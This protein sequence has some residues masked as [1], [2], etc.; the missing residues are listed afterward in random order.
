MLWF[1]SSPRAR[2]ASCSFSGNTTRASPRASS[3][4]LIL[5]GSST[6]P[7]SRHLLSTE[8]TSRCLVQCAQ[9][10]AKAIKTRLQVLDD[11]LGEF[12]RFGQVIE[13]SEALVPEPEHIEACLISRLQLP[14]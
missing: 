9:N 5:T 14:V 10:L 12:V 13:I 7:I 11:F 8:A 1:T 6:R 2:T 3:T 4:N